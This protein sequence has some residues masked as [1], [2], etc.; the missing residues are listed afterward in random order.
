M[1]EKISS[2][3]E[4]QNWKPYA[5]SVAISGIA[6]V[7]RL[8]LSSYLG[9]RTPF[10]SFYPAVFLA[11]VLGGAGPGLL[12][13]AICTAAAVLLFLGR[14]TPLAQ[15]PQQQLALVFFVLSSAV[16]SV[17]CESQKRSFKLARESAEHARQSSEAL[18]QSERVATKR[19]A[20]LE[21]VYDLS[22]IGLAFLDPDLRF[23]RI[24][25]RL[26]QINGKPVEEHIGRSLTEALGE[27][28]KLVEA[29]YREVLR[30]RRP[31]RSAEIVTGSPQGGKQYYLLNLDPVSNPDG[32]LLGIN[33]VV[34]DITAR[35]SEEI[36]TR[37]LAEAT[38][39]LYG[40][41]NFEHTLQKLAEAAVPD[42]ADW[43][44]VDIVQED[45]S[46]HRL[47]TRHKDPAKIRWAEELQLRFPYDPAATTGVP[48]VIRSG[49]SEIYRD[50]TPE[51]IEAAQL[52]DEAREVLEQL[53]L[54]SLMVVPIYARGRVLG[55]LTLVTA[56]SKRH[57]DD[58]DLA[59]AEELGR[60]AGIAV[61]NARLYFEAQREIKERA[62]AEEEVR[63][64]NA[65]LEARVEERTAELKTAVSDLEGFCYSVSHD[66]RAPMRSLSGNS[67]IL[68]EDFSDELTQ[69]GKD[70]LQRIALA[71]SKMGELVDDLLQF[72][73]LGRGE[74]D[75][76]TVNLSELAQL[77]ADSYKSL[78]PESNAIITIE[79][80][81]MDCGDPSVLA[82]AIQNLIDNALKYSSKVAQPKVQFGHEMKDG[83]PVYFVRD[84][85]VGFDMRYAPKIF[86]PFSRLHR[87]AEYPGTGI[88]L[89]NVKRIISRHGGDVWVEAEQGVGATFY[90]TLAPN[91][92]GA[93]P[94]ALD[95]VPPY[96][97]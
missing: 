64:L 30:T 31:L 85:G 61:D 60:R 62:I 36:R 56:E 70:H 79:P 78:H 72:S 32:Q 28:A 7:A 82:L 23:V 55:A 96:L 14:E 86:K 97:G 48:A 21:V 90:F 19:L 95:V 17:L 87:D 92:E 84:N 25:E 74:L 43:C 89:A 66:L 63:N 93:R 41:L 9:F 52:T 20:E 22:P 4:G 76:R 47:A 50:I 38:Q 73:R 45:G 29:K 16:M 39:T 77:A 13:L 49:K 80:D 42:Y 33:V 40:S 94:A 37:L 27:N 34:Q 46:V 67:R 12:S 18:A 11:A 5:I 3:S 71:A 91:E 8:L 65:Q 69:D 6:I 53:A 44:A 81:L 2:G 35:K 68:L 75:F 10:L 1:Q 57:Y 15:D 51:V 24:N 88:G 54:T 26:A 83:K 58:D 59:T